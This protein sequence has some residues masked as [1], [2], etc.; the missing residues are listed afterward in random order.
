MKNFDSFHRYEMCVLFNTE[1]T[2][3]P[4]LWNHPRTVALYFVG[5]EVFLNRTM[6]RSNFCSGTFVR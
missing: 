6:E 3:V 4:A 1:L 2:R 5:S